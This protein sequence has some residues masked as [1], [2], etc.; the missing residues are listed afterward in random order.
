MKK[1]LVLISI[2]LAACSTTNRQIIFECD[3]KGSC[4]KA[5]VIATL[6]SDNANMVITNSATIKYS[7]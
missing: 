2:A 5:N 1:I 3:G 7:K 6:S 4:Q